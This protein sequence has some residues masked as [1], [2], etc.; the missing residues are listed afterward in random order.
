MHVMDAVTVH[1]SVITFRVS[2]YLLILLQLTLKFV[3]DLIQFYLY[4]FSLLVI[5]CIYNL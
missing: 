2:Y 1:S 4:L 3:I 5:P